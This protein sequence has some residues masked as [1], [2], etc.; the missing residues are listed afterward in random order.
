MADNVVEFTGAT[1]HPIE[2]DKVLENMKGKLSYVLIIGWGLEEEG[3]PLMFASS[4]SDL[5][6]GFYAV[7][8]YK[9]AV[10]GQKWDEE[11]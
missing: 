10:L 9:H 3:H 11:D 7:D 4:S 6:E 2:P 1:R 5:R 8:N